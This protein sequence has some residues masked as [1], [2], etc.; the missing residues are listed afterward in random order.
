MQVGIGDSSD[1]QTEI[2]SGLSEGEAVVV[3][4]VAS[5]QRTQ[6]GASPFGLRGGF[7][8]QGGFRAGGAGR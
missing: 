7:G 4:S 5:A 6:T 3:G 8:G 1:T 2:I